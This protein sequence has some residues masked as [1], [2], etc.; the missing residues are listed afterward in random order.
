MSTN[1]LIGI[2]ANHKANP[3]GA[4]QAVLNDAYVRAVLRAGGLP[5]IL[6]AGIPESA[7]AQLFPRLDG[8]L[9]TGGGDIAPARF[10]GRPHAKVYDVLAERDE[11]ETWLVQQAAQGGKPFLGICRGIQVI[12]VALGG[13]LYTHLPDQLPGAVQH[14]HVTGQPY[15]FL[16]HT[17]RVRE[18]SRLAA[19]LG[20]TELGVNSLHHQGVERV[21]P[22]LEASASAPDGLVEAVELPGHPFGV[23]VQWHP[24]WLAELESMQALFRAFVEASSRTD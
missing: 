15:A 24:E 3:D 8:V 13:S 16:A 22:G 2:T 7:L 1:P 19:I 21:A 12:N 4:G 11:L 6:P 14:E 5:L 23:G 9:L 10:N 20:A 18:G 17:V